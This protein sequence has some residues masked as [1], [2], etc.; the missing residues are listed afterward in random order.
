M[1]MLSVNEHWPKGSKLPKAGILTYC[2]RDPGRT[3]RIVRLASGASFLSG[4]RTSPCADR[5]SMD[6][7]H[8]ACH[9]CR[10]DR[11]R[12]SRLHH[13]GRV[14]L[15]GW[16][17]SGVVD[18][19]CFGT[20]TSAP[21]QPRQRAGVS[22][23]G[24]DQRPWSTGRYRGQCG[25][26]DTDHS[27]TAQIE[28]RATRPGRCVPVAAAWRPHRM[29]RPV[30]DRYCVAHYRVR[31]GVVL[32]LG[33]PSW[34]DRPSLPDPV[35][36]VSGAW[37]SDG[38]RFD[39]RGEPVN[40]RA[41]SGNRRSRVNA[42]NVRQLKAGDP[43][44]WAALVN[45][46]G[47]T[48]AGYAR[49]LGASDPDEMVS[50]T[51]E[52]VARSIGS[53]EGTERQLRSFVFKVA[54]DRTV[55]SLRRSAHQRETSLETS[56]VQ[57]KAQETPPTGFED[58]ELLEVLSSLPEEQRRMLDLR[59]VVGLSTKETAAVLGRSEVSTRVA[60]SRTMAKVRIRLSE[61][62]QVSERGDES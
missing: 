53:F 42:L 37:R 23:R 6:G 39:D 5:W 30:G 48:I 43:K 20:A 3:G 62:H 4:W 2:L 22:G 38:Y 26:H 11:S 33:T 8:G 29:V 28:R 52:A 14:G 19:G 47:P 13:R 17:G 25:D 16:D 45:E 49:R 56:S 58:P 7:C 40:V 31:S 10:R 60:L 57:P 18:R 51:L 32:M 50:A 9:A 24:G 46:L 36:T 59:Y 34:S 21:T 55:D 54:H 15:F 61:Q 41:R 35:W 27:S 12:N 44:T 1:T